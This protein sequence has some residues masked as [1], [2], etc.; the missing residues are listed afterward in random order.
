MSA[1]F[2]QSLAAAQSS[3]YSSLYR[4]ER[5]GI[6]A[7]GI[8]VTGG[9]RLSSAERVANQLLNSSLVISAG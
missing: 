8:K 7:N 2:A 6:A 4:F 1:S 5:A 3:R 9:A